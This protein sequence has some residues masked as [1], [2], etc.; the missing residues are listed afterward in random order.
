MKRPRLKK[1]LD[2]PGE[3]LA[4]ALLV[5]MT[6]LVVVLGFAR[7]VSRTVSRLFEEAARALGLS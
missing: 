3:G 2:D 1:W 5:L 7:L 6:C 4:E